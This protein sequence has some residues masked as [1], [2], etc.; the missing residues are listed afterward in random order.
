MALFSMGTQ[1]FGAFSE[2]FLSKEGP[3]S[4]PENL[5]REKIKPINKEHIKEFAGRYASAE[6]SGGRFGGESRDIRDVPT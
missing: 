2:Q 1:M 4:P 5:R 3:D 6:V